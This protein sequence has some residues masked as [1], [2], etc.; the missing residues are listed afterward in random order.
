M[1]L[2][3]NCK[4]FSPGTAKSLESD[5]EARD[6]AGKVNNAQNVKIQA[7]HTKNL[8]FYSKVREE[9]RNDLK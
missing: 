5:Q 6:E 2:W 8:D 3:Q 7:S 9:T 4:L 1:G